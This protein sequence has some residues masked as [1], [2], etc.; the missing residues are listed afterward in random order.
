[1]VSQAGPTQKAIIAVVNTAGTATVDTAESDGA[2]G[3][4]AQPLQGPQT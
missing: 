1:M 2:A 4:Q 3:Q